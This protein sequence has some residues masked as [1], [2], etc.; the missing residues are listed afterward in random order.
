[1]DITIPF[2]LTWG[3]ILTVSRLAYIP[4]T[5]KKKRLRKNSWMQK[6]SQRRRNENANFHQSSS[7]HPSQPLGVVLV[8]LM[9]IALLLR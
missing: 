6:A 7:P 9:G 8:S 3:A 5:R 1:M 4:T 2:A